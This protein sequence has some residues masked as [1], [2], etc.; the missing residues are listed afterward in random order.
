M[1]S[2]N[3]LVSEI[4]HS[5][6]QADTLLYR[7]AIGSINVFLIMV[8]ITACIDRCDKGTIRQICEKDRA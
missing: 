6:Q 8:F 3:Q 2:I 5:L 4:A 1:A 7:L